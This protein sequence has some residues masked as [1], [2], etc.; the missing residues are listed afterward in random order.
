LSGDFDTT[1]IEI[2]G[3][4]IA[5]D[6]RSSPDRYV[7]TPDYFAAVK[8]PLLQGR[9]FNQQDNASHKYVA[10]ISQTAARMLFPG[11]SPIGKK[12]RAGSA[13]GDWE[14]SPYREIVGIAGDVEQYGLGLPSRPQIYMPYAQ[15]ADGYVTLILRTAGDPTVLTAPLRRAVL[16]TDAEQPIYDVIP[17]ESLVEDSIAAR[18]MSTWILAGFA[19]GALALAAIGIYG[20]ISYSVARRR[21]EFAIRMALGARPIDVSKEAVAAGVPMI[22]AGIVVGLGGAFAVR[23]LLDSFL[24]GVSSMDLASFIGVPLGLLLIALAACYVP[25]HQAAQVEP[26]EALKYE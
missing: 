15:Y 1:G 2:S 6:E 20:V 22:F 12:I 21:Q 26:L 25:A 10:V 11:E 14:H 9:L 4:M 3:K 17:F 7:V 13:S 19:L 16:A 18:R 8:I 23:K 24:F 5:A